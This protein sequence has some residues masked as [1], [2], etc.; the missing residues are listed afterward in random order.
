MTG[1]VVLIVIALAGGRGAS[2]PATGAA[3]IVPADAL[4]FVDVSTDASRPAVKDTVALLRRLPTYATSSATVLARVVQAV[5][6]DAPVGFL[7]DI[8]PWLGKEAAIAFLNTTSSAAGSLIVLDVANRAQARAF[9]TRAGATRAGTYRGVA[10]LRYPGGTELAFV[11]HY[12]ILGQDAS[13]RASIDVSTGAAA[14]LAGYKPYTEAAA[15]EPSDRVLAAYASGTGV[16]RI[17]ASRQGDLGAL[18]VLLYKPA[19]QA[20]A[21]SVS[22]ASGGLR[23]HIHTELDRALAELSGHP[24][25]LIAPKL[26]SV[27]PANATLM[28]DVS[29]LARA[30]PELLSAGTTAGIAGQ[31]GPLLRRLGAA[32][33]A[34]GV[35]VHSLD[36]IF[37]GETAVLITPPGPLSTSP[38]LA[39]VARTSNPAQTRTTLASLEVPLAQLFPAPNAGP[40]QAPEFDDVQIAGIT[41]HELSLTTGL[42]IDYAV[43]DGLVVVSTS[44]S[45]IAAVLGSRRSLASQSEFQ[46]A[47]DG[48]PQ[49]VS[50]LLFLDFSQLLSLGEQTGL[51]RSAGSGA[52]T[53]DLQ[54]I[55]AVGMDSTSG[56]ADTTAEL[57]L[58]IP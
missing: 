37:A 57:F 20:V 2:G 1:A 14:S 31:V 27:L 15:G 7:S 26:P 18:G 32:L 48:R 56:E 52:L 45:G 40:G 47:L 33:A 51:A 12:L 58:Q 46:T 43:A 38:S 6:G 13:V 9:L 49:R 10:L 19:L 16:Q 5:G 30:A 39:I 17:L 55:R 25:A 28:F 35:N 34:E 22:P 24:S 54:S 21:I 4:A 53:P 8:R 11:Q 36:S 42:K 23:V 29:D 50:S 41:A 3:A 44:R